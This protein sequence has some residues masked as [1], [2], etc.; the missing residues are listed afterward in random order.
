MAEMVAELREGPLGRGE[1]GAEQQ[2]SA[3]EEGHCR[4][5]SGRGLDS[6]PGPEPALAAVASG[7][8][9]VLLL[10]LSGHDETL[11]SCKDLLPFLEGEAKFFEL[12]V[13]TTL[14]GGDGPLLLLPCSP[15]AT[16]LTTHLIRP[17]LA[18]SNDPR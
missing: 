16:T 4:T 5:P 12:Q 1:T 13:A 14:D 9:G 18:I 2:A 15:S 17:S 8:L 10:N 7:K 3:R 11:K 6:I